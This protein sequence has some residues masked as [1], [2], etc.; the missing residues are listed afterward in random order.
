MIVVTGGAG[1]IGSC[2]VAELNRRGMSDIV[3]VDRWDADGLKKHNL[4]GKSYTAFY[5]K[6]DFLQQVLSD[7]IKG[8]VSAIVH[9]GACSSTTGQD[10]EYYRRNNF[11]YSCHMARWALRKKA[12]F[13]YASSAATYGGG[14]NGYADAPELIRQCKPLNYYGASKQM[15]DAWVLDQNLYD[16]IVGLKFFNVFGPNEYHKGD[17]K[18]VI[19]KAYDKVAD[20]GRMVLFKSHRAG[21]ADGEQMRD[22]IYVKDVVDVVAWFLDTPRVN[23]IYNVGTG[24]ARTWNALAAALFAAAGRPVNIEY[25]PMPELLRDKYQYFTEADMARLRKAGYV[26]PFTPLEDAVRDYARYLKDHSYM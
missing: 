26:R 21:F 18:S 7:G 22:F 12:R 10:R 5:D 15:F 25:V 20:E 11:E 16:K 4:A 19:A 6:C 2:V 1:F 13:I 8:E 17:M 14:E 3:V 23:G 24:H 9:M